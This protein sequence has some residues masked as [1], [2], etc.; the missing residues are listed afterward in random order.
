MDDEICQTFYF[1]LISWLFRV[2]FPYIYVNNNSGY[3]GAWLSRMSFPLN[4]TEVVM[5]PRRRLTSR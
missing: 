5:I 2:N 1:T 4:L 3:T